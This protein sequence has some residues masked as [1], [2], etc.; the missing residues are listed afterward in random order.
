MFVEVLLVIIL[1]LA[2]VAASVIGYQTGK[3]Q[4]QR[5]KAELV[6]AVILPALKEVFEQAEYLPDSSIPQELIEESQMFEEWSD[7]H[8]EDYVSGLYKGLRIQMSDIKLWHHTS[9][10]SARAEPFTGKV[11]EF[12]GQ[13]LVCDFGKELATRV[14]LQPNTDP[15]YGLF[16]SFVEEQ[17][18]SVKMENPEFNEIYTVLADDPLVAYYVLT[19]HVMEYIIEANNKTGGC[20]SME[21]LPGGTVHIAIDSDNNYWL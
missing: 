9:S 7:F 6:D 11:F 19:P 8:G 10:R 14:T 2:G 5:K 18:P 16:Q 1:L 20:L 12:C 21:F 13:W 4:R 15:D 3:R 17:V